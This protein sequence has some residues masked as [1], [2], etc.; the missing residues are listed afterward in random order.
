MAAM[1][2]ET[3]EIFH[4][5]QNIVPSGYVAIDELIAPTIQVLNQKG[6][7]TMFCC[8]GHPL[9]EELTRTTKTEE[10]YYKTLAYFAS[11][12]VFEEGITLPSVPPDFEVRRKIPGT[13]SASRLTIDKH[14]TLSKT[15]DNPFFEMAQQILDTMKQLYQWALELPDFEDNKKKEV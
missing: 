6:Y 15:S 4:N 2:T 7:T 9:E 14:Y 5:D 8:S 12:I 1:H 10:G 13:K 11:Y 3:F